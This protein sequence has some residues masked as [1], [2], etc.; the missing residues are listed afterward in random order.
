MEK[1]PLQ[2][3]SPFIGVALFVAAL[4]VLHGELKAYRLHDIMG[5]LHGIPR[6]K[7]L[8]ALLLTVLSYLTM[9]FYDFLALKYIERPLHPLKT[10]FASFVGYAFSNSVGF[11]M[12]AGASVRFRL[13]SSWGLSGLEISKIIAF[14]TVSIWLGFLSLG[15][16]IF[17][18]EPLAIP[19]VLHLPFT[20]V[21]PVGYL[22]LVPVIA[23]FILG[24]LRTGPVTIRG[25]SLT[26]PK[27]TLF[28][29]QVAIAMVDWALAGAVLYE[30]LPDGFTMS[31]PAFLGIFLFAQLAGLISQIPG[32][33]GVFETVIMVFLSPS[34]TGSALFG[35]LIIYRVIY[36]L[37]PLLIAATLLGSQEVRERRRMIAKG[38]V[39]LTQLIRPLV[40][41]VLAILT[42]MGGIVL[43]VSGAT[44]A[45]PARMA[46]IRHFIPLPVIEIS[47]F[48]GS[49]AGVGL[50]LLARGLQ[51]RIDAAYYLTL[52]L[53]VLGSMVSLLK[54]F[55]YEETII[56]SVL[57]LILISSRDVFYRRAKVLW[58]AF[59]PR[60]TAAVAS[61]VIAVAWLTFFSYK[62]VEYTSDL[63]WRFA[64]F[65]N[66]PRSLRA[67]VGV[68]VSILAFTMTR[69]IHP[70]PSPR[71]PGTRQDMERAAAV[72]K[73]SPDSSDNLALLGDKAFLFND[74]GTAFIMYGTVGRTWIALGDPVGPEEEWEELT[75]RFREL[76]DQHAALPV[77]YEVGAENLPVYIDLGLTLVKIGEQGRV[78]L[79]EFSLEGKARRDLR[80]TVSKLGREGCSFR[81]IDQEGVPG[82]LPDLRRVS[83][84]WLAAKN[85]KE[86]GFSLGFFR[87]DY[88]ANFPVAV[89]SIGDKIVAF[90]NIWTSGQ[91]AELSVDLMRYS[92]EAPASVM[93]YLFIQIM[94]WGKEQG[95]HWFNLGMVPLSG[96]EN[97]PM[98]PLWNRFGSFV[99]RHAEHFY[100]FQGLQQYKNKFSPVWEPRFLASSGTLTLPRVLTSLATI[101]SGG[102]KGII[103]K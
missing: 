8:Y 79:A 81:I 97:R 19:S 73:T 98:A 67:M 44:P 100:N 1:R 68:A 16:I 75:W 3:I 11:S 45:V 4:W 64:F 66:A 54:G 93:E 7:I 59:T 52:G 41:P 96:L 47:H 103:A 56:L 91:D 2:L 13:Y 85:T 102:L 12:L 18:L 9:T 36:Y 31:L 78:P 58:S 53:L 87:E 26:L 57:L 15:G 71:A 28:F 32:G 92:S 74:A 10:A 80:Y 55:D 14:C 20:S 34:A 84:A 27:P 77:F 38:A 83:D 72:V 40:P 70:A 21:H 90:A 99:F 48:L 23:Y 94:L 89:V 24:T 69:L 51:L 86:K 46:W 42:F 6:T 62:H 95:Y 82:V 35:S 30:L 5:Y 101:T 29:A 50:L 17:I 37:L 22:L 25:L 39:L 49:V 63:W 76:C 88:V 65:E 43:L 33:L 60:W 61:A